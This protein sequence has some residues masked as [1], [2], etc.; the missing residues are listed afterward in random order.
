[1]VLA[2]A[3]FLE[4]G[5]LFCSFVCAAQSVAPASSA[6]VVAPP[7]AAAPPPASVAVTVPAGPSKILAP[8][9]ENVEQTLSA[10]KTDRWKR[11]TV[12]DEASANIAAILKDLQKSLPPLIATA[13]T[14]PETLSKVLPMAKNVAALYDVLLR[15]NEAARVSA[16]GD[17][18]AQLEQTLERL[19]KARLVMDDHLQDLAAALEKQLGDLQAAV[20]AQAAI[21]CPAVP[22]P[23]VPVCTPPAARKVKKKPAAKPTQTAPPAAPAAT[24]STPKT[25]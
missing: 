19:R 25:Q 7:A 11:G 9:L 12:R 3:V 16:P 10:I 4:A 1:M 17:Q 21:R 14:Q 22:P 2:K 20:K 18:V 13:D 5:L 23:T 8:A 15:V 6:P 24:P